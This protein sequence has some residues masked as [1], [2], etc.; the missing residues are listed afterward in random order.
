MVN[1]AND[2]P[3]AK[4]SVIPETVTGGEGSA[5][6]NI[7]RRGGPGR[8]RKEGASG[9]NV[10]DGS[11]YEDPYALDEEDP[12]FDSEEETGKEKIPR[13]VIRQRDRIGDARITLTQYKKA[14][15]PIINEFFSSGDFNDLACSLEVGRTAEL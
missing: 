2:H 4:K 9:G 8:A 3:H 6:R 5:K 10:D 15:V 7:I 11:L 12:N 1:H 14:V 13:S